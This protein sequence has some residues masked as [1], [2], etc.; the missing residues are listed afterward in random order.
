[1]SSRKPHSYFDRKAADWDVLGF[2]EDC[3]EKT[4]KNKMDIY[5][6]SLLNIVA[7]ERQGKRHEK[8]KNLLDR[9][10]RVCSLFM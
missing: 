7:Y 6:K 2:L 10:R 5:V 9:Y 1:M 3:N 8:A 4:L